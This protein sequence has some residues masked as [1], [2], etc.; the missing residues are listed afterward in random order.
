MFSNLWTVPISG[1]VMFMGYRNTTLEGTFN[2]EKEIRKTNFG[3]LIKS[4]FTEV[5]MVSAQFN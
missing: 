1:S 4:R 5:V 2:S 3:R